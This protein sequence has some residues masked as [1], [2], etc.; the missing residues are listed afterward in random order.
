MDKVG[1]P[2]ATQNRFLA[3]L[4]ADAAPCGDQVKTLALV[5][6]LALAP[7]VSFRRRATNIIV[8]KGRRLHS[9][10]RSPS[11][12]VSRSPS[13]MTTSF[14]HQMYVEGLFDYR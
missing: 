6:L 3:R 11:A 4:A 1:L 2:F 7:A 12:S 9:G 13:P 10:A 8:Q 14:I 5:L